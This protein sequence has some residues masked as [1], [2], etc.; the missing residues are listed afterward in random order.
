MLGIVSPK[1]K[2]IPGNITQHL[3][4]ESLL[5]SIFPDRKC[6]NDYRLNALKAYI[7]AYC[8]KEHIVFLSQRNKYKRQLK[9]VKIPV[10]NEHYL[11]QIEEK[12]NQILVSHK[13][14]SKTISQRSFW[15]KNNNNKLKVKAISV[16]GI[17]VGVRKNLS[18]SHFY[19]LPVLCLLFIKIF[20]RG[21][22]VQL[23]CNRSKAKCFIEAIVI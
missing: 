22:F 11:T 6:E 2:M 15:F 18:C 10:P 13:K 5:M 20:K 7:N 16:R 9:K 3:V 12:I 14:T 19:C 8:K 21:S 17:M 1:I 23:F 4:D